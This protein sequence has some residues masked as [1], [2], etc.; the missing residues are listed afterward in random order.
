[1]INTLSKNQ[2]EI[3]IKNKTYFQSYNSVICEIDFGNFEIT[4]YKDFDF[5]KTTSKYRNEFLKNNNF[6]NLASTKA[7]EKAIDDGFCVDDTFNN[8]DVNFKLYFEE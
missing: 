1:M 6:A 7:I 5:S 4:F 8:F 2:Y 3:T